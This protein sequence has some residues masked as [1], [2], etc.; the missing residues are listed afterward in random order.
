MR[1]ILLIIFSFLIS[2]MVQG[3]KVLLLE[4][5][6]EIRPIKFYEG[7]EIDVK[8]KEYPKDWETLK[9]ERF[10][11]EEQIIVAEN[12]M[13][14]LSEISH[15]R[16]ERKII[17]NIYLATTSLAVSGLVFGGIGELYN[18]RP[19]GAL[20]VAV[21][22]GIVYGTGWLI[23]KLLRYRKYKLGN[24]YRLKILDVSFPDPQ[25]VVPSPRL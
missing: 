6:A 23:N 4:D 20:G 21:L 25:K 18:G 10:L 22:S 3:Q 24:K 12:G 5:R 9:I 13:Y 15:V 17:K 16:I 1:H 14:K 2:H 7:Q 11:D 8:L 19:A